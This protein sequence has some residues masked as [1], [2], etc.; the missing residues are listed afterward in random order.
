MIKN[1]ILLGFILFSNLIN[2]MSAYQNIKPDSRAPG[3]RRTAHLLKLNPAFISTYAN[4][5]VSP[6]A[7]SSIYKVKCLRK[8]TESYVAT[9]DNGDEISCT[10][11]PTG[12]C[13]GEIWASAGQLASYTHSLP[14]P[15][16][17]F[18]ILKEFYEKPAKP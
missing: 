16:K 13:E 1:S 15:Q 6:E 10:F 9:L 18:F 11:V 12:E 17:N 7:I 14:I 8:S 2:G 3:L 4:L 5:I